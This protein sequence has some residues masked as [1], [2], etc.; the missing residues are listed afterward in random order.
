[1]LLRWSWRFWNLASVASKALGQ[2]AKGGSSNFAKAFYLP[3]RADSFVSAL[4]KWLSEYEADPFQ[5][6][7]L[8]PPL[9]T[10]ALLDRYHS[11]T[12]KCASCSKA[13]AN[14][15]RLRLGIAIVG[16]IAWATLPLLTF[17]LGTSI[18]LAILCA[19]I[20]LTAGAAWLWLG[21]LERQ[22]YEGRQVP[23]R[24]LPERKNSNPGAL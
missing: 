24:N 3:T 11:H 13:L 5:G 7:P 14:I 17:I 21:K 12:L 4:R 20:P 23:P 19:V 18:L 16:A 10:E 1:M 22:F 15:K 9:P 2:K 6:E 8:P